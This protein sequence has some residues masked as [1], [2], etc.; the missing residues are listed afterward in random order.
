MDRA[1]SRNDSRGTAAPPG[2]VGGV[3]PSR[4]AGANGRLEPGN[5]RLNDVIGDHFSQVIY[6][7]C[8]GGR[9]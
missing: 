5:R 1:H 7:R 9:W 2:E 3:V 4:L 8:T 6:H